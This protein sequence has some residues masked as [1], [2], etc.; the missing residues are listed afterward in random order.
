MSSTAISLSRRTFLRG[1]TLGLAVALAGCTALGDASGERQNDD[2]TTT[3]VNEQFGFEVTYPGDWRL[4]EESEDVSE[5]V[6]AVRVPADDRFVVRL[7][8]DADRLSTPRTLDSVA[9]AELVGW[10][11]HA[12]ADYEVMSQRR[13]TLPGDVQADI[14]D[15]T[16]RRSNGSTV[17]HKMLNAVGQSGEVRYYVDFIASIEWYDRMGFDDDVETVFASFTVEP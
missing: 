12:E 6:V 2:G 3:Y 5:G 9:T 15:G 13:V 4:D 14:V 11:R 1:T 8:V 16:F 7:R 17:R 10:Q